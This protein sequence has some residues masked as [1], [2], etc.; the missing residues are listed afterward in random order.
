MH[1]D[2]PKYSYIGTIN[3]TA[4]VI[5]LTALSWYGIVPCFYKSNL[6]VH[7]TG[8]HAQY[9]ITPDVLLLRNT[10]TNFSWRT[11]HTQKIMFKSSGSLHLMNPHVVC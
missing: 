7:T 8:I 3:V 6:N 4:F 1:F 10:N 5:G 9:V 2:F 11:I